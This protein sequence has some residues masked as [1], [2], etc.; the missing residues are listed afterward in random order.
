MLVK[1]EALITAINIIMQNI[2]GR[3]ESASDEDTIGM[4]VE[5]DSIATV[6]DADGCAL[7]DKDG[8]VLLL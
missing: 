8:T 1:F 5:Q 7:M 6:V 4:L 2:F 3:T